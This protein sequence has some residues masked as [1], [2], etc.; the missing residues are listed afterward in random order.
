MAK[1]EGGIA[2]EA[3]KGVAGAASVGV[4]AWV[5]DWL[6][7]L[8]EYGSTALKSGWS[9]LMASSSMPNWMAY[10]MSFTL[11]ISALRWALRAWASR[12]DNHKRF[13]QF[14]FMG[15]VWRWNFMSGLIG[16]LGVYCPQCDGALVYS[17]DINA[18]QIWEVSWHCERCSCIRVSC[19]GDKGYLDGRVKREI[20]RLV[21]TGKWRNY[22]D[23]T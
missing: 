22:V 20:D 23:K 9:H 17:N 4:F 21:R 3:W 1:S 16:N 5:M 13:T 10:A 14:N 2:S 18:R 12:K 15:G 8:W 19:E 7:P 6:K 11:A